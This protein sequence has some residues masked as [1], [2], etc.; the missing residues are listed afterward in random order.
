MNQ[1]I[2]EIIVGLSTFM[3]TLIPIPLENAELMQLKQ[4]NMHMNTEWAD[5]C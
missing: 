4:E 2:D 1:I 5:L 3:Y